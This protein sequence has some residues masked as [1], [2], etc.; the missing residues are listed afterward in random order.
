MF[1]L[2]NLIG[3]VV[4][5]VKECIEDKKSFEHTLAEAIHTECW[6]NNPLSPEKVAKEDPVVMGIY[7][8]F[9]Y[10]LGLAQ[11]M[12]ACSR[13]GLSKMKRWDVE[14]QANGASMHSQMEGN[15]ISYRNSGKCEFGIIVEL[16]RTRRLNVCFVFFFFFFLFFV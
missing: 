6:P 10:Q 1:L 7:D 4:N 3:F 2:L 14:I 8:C 12:F 13:D 5:E 9:R 16:N 11:M 15:E